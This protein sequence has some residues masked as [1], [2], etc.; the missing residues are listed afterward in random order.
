M[1][2]LSVKEF[3][4]STTTDIQKL[5][6]FAQTTTDQSE[7]LVTSTAGNVTTP[8]VPQGTSL[9]AA[10]NSSLE[11]IPEATAGNISADIKPQGTALDA[12]N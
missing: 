4:L 5:G 2:A 12:E 10:N 3:Y 11:N 1:A 6:A 7:D 8:I 9:D